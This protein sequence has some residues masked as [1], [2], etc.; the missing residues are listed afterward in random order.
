[1][2]FSDLDYSCLLQEAEAEFRDAFGATPRPM[3]E[4]GLSETQI[5]KKLLFLIEEEAKLWRELN[6]LHNRNA[7]WRNYFQK[8]D[9]IDLTQDEINWNDIRKENDAMEVWSFCYKQ[10]KETRSLLGI[11]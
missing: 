6:R 4:V 5:Q 3:L 9:V 2:D 10:L 8:A 1:M 11:N 7:V